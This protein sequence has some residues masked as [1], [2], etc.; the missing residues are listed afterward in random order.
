MKDM[1]EWQWLELYKKY[2]S[3]A[4]TVQ[5]S[6]EIECTPMTIRLNFLRR[7]LKIRNIKDAGRNRTVHNKNFDGTRLIQKYKNVLKAMV[8]VNGKLIKESHF[9]YCQHYNITEIPEDYDIHHIDNNPLNNSIDNL[10]LLKHSEHTKLHW[11]NGK[12]GKE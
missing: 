9:V 5:L 7:G 3:G 6:K 2:E 12:N 11:R 10:Q 8:K 1:Y 4:S